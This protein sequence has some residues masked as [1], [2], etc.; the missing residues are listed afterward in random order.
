[1]NKTLRVLIAEDSERDR[2]MLERHLST[3]GYSLVTD[4]VFTANTFAAALT[5]T[6]W[7]LIICDYSMHGFNAPRALK[8]LHAS[9]LD[10]PFIIISGSIGEET[11]VEALLSGANDYIPKDNLTRL[12]PAIERE[13]QEAENRRVRRRAESER[14]IIGEIIQGI[15]AAPNLDEFLKLVHS[16][17]GEIISAEN[18]FLMLRD[19]VGDLCRF[20]FWVDQRDPHPPPQCADKGFACYVMNSR[21]PLLLTREIRSEIIAAGDAEQ[22]G[23]SSASWIGVPLLASDSSIGVLVLQNYDVENAYTRRDLDFLESVGDHIALAIERK[24]SVKMLIESEERYR[25]LVENA[26]DIIYT[27]DMNGNYTSVNGAVEL[28]TGYTRNEVLSMNSRQLIA[29]EFIEK[30]SQMV[31]DKLAGKDVTSYD[32]E[33]ITKDGQRKTIE[34]NTR[35]LFENE[36]A[37]GVQGIARDISD[38][39]RQELARLAFEQR[40]QDIFNLAPVGIYQSKIDGTLLTVNKALAEMLGY[41]STD[42]LLKINLADVYFTADERGKLVNKYQNIRYV[43]DLEI[44]WKKNDGSPIWIQLTCHITSSAEGGEE[45]FEGFVRDVTES[46]RAENVLRRQAEIFAQSFDAVIVW[47]WNGPIIFW[48]TGA[49]QLYKINHK[50]AIGRVSH[51]LLETANL[52]GL[53][54]LTES[55]RKNGHFEAELQHVTG[56]GKTIIVET[57]M[58]LIH[59]EAGDYVIETNRDITERKQKDEA[60]VA[61]DEKF[62]QLADNITDAFWIRSSDMSEVLYV[63]PAFEQIW[64]RSVSELYS[65]PGGWIDFLHP[66]DRKWVGRAFD[67]LKGKKTTLEVEYRILRAEG[68]IRWIRTRA[69]PVN[70]N[71]GRLIRYAGIVTDITEQKRADEA[72]RESE[73]RLRAIVDTEPECVKLIAADGALLEMNPA[74]LR[75]IEADSFDQVKSQNINQLIVKEHRGAFRDLTR[76]VFQGESGALEFEID[77]LL[78]TR[79]WMDTHATPLRNASGDITALLGISRD[80]TE[81]KLADEALRESEEKYRTILESIEDGYF[82]VDLAGN[83]TFFNSSLSET[84]GYDRHELRGMNNRNY[85]DEA[86]AKIVFQTFNDV[87]KTG[88]TVKGMDWEITRKDGTRRFVETSIARRDDAN[89]KPIGFRGL[90]RDITERKDLEDRFR[91]SQKMEAIGVLAGGIAHDFNNLLTAIN[92]YSDLVLKQLRPDDPIK[93]QITEIKN[94]G[95][96]A[97]SLTSQLLAFSR[98]QILKPRVHNLNSVITEI[99]KMLQRI[100]RENIE[101]KTKLAPELGNIKADP[102]QIEQVI[103]NLAVNARD[104]MPQGGTLLIETENFYI[105]K[106]Y[107]S[108]NL[109]VRPGNFARI[110]VTDTGEGMDEDTQRRIFDP[111]FTTKE[112]GKGTGLGLSTVYGIVKQSGGDIMVYSEPGQG[113]T[114]K[115]YLPCVDEQI[116]RPKWAGD[117]EENLSGSE[118]VLLVEDEDVVRNLVNEILSSSGYK[119]LPASTGEAAIELAQMYTESIDLLLT[120]VIMPKISGTEL[121]KT[122]SEIKP[123]IKVLFMSGYTDDAISQGGLLNAGAAFIEKPFTPEKLTRKIRELLSK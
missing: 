109:A 60:L 57:R 33:I 30:A 93:G 47:E 45:Y 14:K 39:K 69:F 113:T 104:A 21:K 35:I 110:A 52:G 116:Q 38:R 15:M 58:K 8:L 79:R 74:G 97:A 9:G 123:D 11:A 6:E 34:I 70:D 27:H 16:S 13:L 18:C 32:I 82:E 100:I 62:H 17:I 121:Q 80:V 29:P 10:I 122:I 42:E 65:N 87:F 96:R 102:G 44:Q 26:I 88:R 71:S 37:V 5:S 76:R 103:M 78:G 85:T 20:E 94:A 112:V 92:G 115:I 36:N 119:V 101:L 111:F 75:M 2:D 108:E 51:D 46:R 23:S 49:E 31:S 48:T 63:S 59:D 86:Q 64:G 54:S 73:S 77:G 118:T 56:D 84:I 98:K 43:I 107:V 4:C 53:S 19:A 67:E 89:G 12:I 90:V 81:R 61:S 7:D 105:D 28:V 95:D 40:Y 55:L 120:D 25:E 91:Q 117:S 22:V 114:F 24:R 3:A 41:D 72:L 68:E 83:F 106:D 66:D 50:D 1:M 99:E